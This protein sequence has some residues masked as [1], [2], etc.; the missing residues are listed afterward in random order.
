MLDRIA[1]THCKLRGEKGHWKAE[2]PNK[3]K[4]NVNIAVSSQVMDHSTEDSF[5]TYAPDVLVEETRQQDFRFD[6]ALCSFVCYAPQELNRDKT[7]KSSAISF[8]S[9]RIEQRKHSKSK[10]APSSTLPCIPDSSSSKDR[11]TAFHVTTDG[12]YAVLDT[13]ASRSVIGSELVP[14]LLK[15]LSAE[16]CA[17]VKEVPS[18]VGFRFGNNQVLYSKSQSGSFVS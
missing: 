9:C 8:L 13:G 16:V 18:H 3:S 14:S 6:H 4:E 10:F 15:N 7:W 11:S 17:R 1:K 12:S 5:T 2:C